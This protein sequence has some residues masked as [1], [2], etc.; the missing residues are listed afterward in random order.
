VWFSKCRV[1]VANFILT[2][3]SRHRN[4]QV[5]YGE[6]P[7]MEGYT[8]NSLY[9]EFLNFSPIFFCCRFEPVNT[10]SRPT[11]DRRLMNSKPVP[12]TVANDD[13]SNARFCEKSCQA[14]STRTSLPR[15]RLHPL[16]LA[17]FPFFLFSEH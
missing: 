7:A 12:V 2:T 6:L 15:C 10:H 8:C 17:I 14:G 11:A 13:R 3:I 5:R 4:L 9:R 1:A 16:V